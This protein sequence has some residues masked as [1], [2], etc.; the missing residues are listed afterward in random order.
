MPDVL[1][2][3][4]AIS[5][6]AYSKPP[7]STLSF[8]P[9]LD[10]PGPKDTNHLATD[11]LWPGLDVLRLSSSSLDLTQKVDETAADSKVEDLHM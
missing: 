6:I 4:T 11:S 3:T 1:S 10:R 8:L 9:L 7:Q 5:P 2:R